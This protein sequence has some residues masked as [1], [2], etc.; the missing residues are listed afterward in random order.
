MLWI[1]EKDNLLPGD[2]HLQ[3]VLRNSGVPF[4]ELTKTE[5][6]VYS[7][8]NLCYDVI[9]KQHYPGMVRGSVNFCLMCR[10][11]HFLS[12]G[13]YYWPEVYKTTNY[14]TILGDDYLNSDHVL[15]QWGNL[16]HS[17]YRMYLDNLMENNP[18]F[19]RPVSGS[20]QFSGQ[21][22][23]LINDKV[24]DKLDPL[25]ILKSDDLLLFSPVKS[26]LCEWR[27]V[28]CKGKVIAGSKYQP[29][30]E[31]L[32]PDTY[33]PCEPWI[34][35]QKIIDRLVGDYYTNEEGNLA[36]LVEDLFTLDI[37][38]AESNQ[39]SPRFLVPSDVCFKVVEVNSFSAAGLYE[40]NLQAIIDS[41]GVSLVQS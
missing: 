19:C 41:I 32:I 21:I 38:L 4:K 35:A 24:C 20:K 13:V 23:S 5:I 33:A 12:N 9:F 29:Y 27:F 37:C 16:K 39:K 2:D 18:A 3:E 15:V 7:N 28:V 22:V 10:G 8:D 31:A 25:N 36:C 26:V 1:F 40:C 11:N 6:Y 17:D 14:T 30:S 34:Y